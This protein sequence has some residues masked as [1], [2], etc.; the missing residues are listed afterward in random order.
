MKSLRV[1]EIL[2]R[3]RQGVTRPFLCRCDDGGSYYVKGAYAGRR[4]LIAE[5][6][7]GR[8]ARGLDLP[9]P[10]F[11][12]VTVPHDIIATSDREDAQELGSGACFGSQ[13]ISDSSELRF[14]QV[15]SLPAA[16]PARILLFDWW[17]L[18]GDR[19]LSEHGGNP[20]LLR[21]LSD[22]ALHIIDHNLAF[23]S[24][25][26][27]QFWNQHIFR[28]AR[29]DWHAP[30]RRASEERMKCLLDHLTV[31]WRELPES[32]REN[33]DQTGADIRRALAR[34]EDEPDAFW[35]P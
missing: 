12:V 26:A 33:A 16:L 10:P 9:I 31:W 8:L 19:T 23:E 22:G 34:F 25:A 13:V 21:R 7:A 30:F 18:N 27:H 29:R 6:L 28:A 24:D 3:A 14:S 11:G 35:G 17:L 1:I 5:L 32:W 15:P 20:N 2:D 4:G